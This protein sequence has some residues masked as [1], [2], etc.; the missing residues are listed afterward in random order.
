MIRKIVKISVIMMVIGVLSSCNSN[1]AIE[2]IPS[3]DLEDKEIVTEVIEMEE[4]SMSIRPVTSL[5]PL[6]EYDV[7]V[8]EK[9]NLVYDKLFYFDEN[10][11]WA[12]DIVADYTLDMTTRQL[13]IGLKEDVY[14][15]NGELMTAVDVANSI[16]ILINADEN[17]YYKDKVRNIS[18]YNVRNMD[19][20]QKIVLTFAS[21][22]PLYEIDLSFPIVSSKTY[23]GTSYSMPYGSGNY[24]LDVNDKY[25]EFS[26]TDNPYDDGT[27]NI[28]K[29]NFTVIDNE[30]TEIY[31]FENGII[32]SALTSP[33]EWLKYKKN[34]ESQVFA[35]DRNELEFIG[36]NY[37]NVLLQDINMR[38]AISRAI[39]YEDILED[40]YVNYGELTN[41]GVNPN[42]WLYNDD[43]EP[44]TKSVSTAKKLL[45]DNGYILNS[46]TNTRIKT[47]DGKTYNANFNI[48]VNS[49]N[50]ERVHLANILQSSLESIG[51]QT[52][53]VSLG[54]EEYILALNNKEFDLFI[55][56]MVV[57]SSQLFMKVFT[58]N[59]P[60][61]YG[62]ESLNTLI[63]EISVVTTNDEFESKHR[64]IQSLLSSATTFIPLLYK[65]DVFIVDG[66]VDNAKVF[67]D[68]L[69]YNVDEWAYSKEHIYEK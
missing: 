27:P 36:F 47:I 35:Y 45:D 54:Y 62:S 53:I 20:I 14:F 59:N 25:L 66:E 56:G 65:Y 46:V 3:N 43:I 60:F 22:T 24:L 23:E 39:S 5:N 15:G 16:G 12:S 28:K 2:S 6:L 61:S 58:G 37:N 48:L 26:F 4:M 30:V 51:I 10:M 33:N 13:V 50:E 52:N 11:K 42:S 68:N 18:S 38:Q 55:G 9:L 49:D 17:V 21:N 32:N 41:T 7:D 67:Y 63:E 1:I 69:F 19:G 34:Y 57:D 8:V 64:E 31:S 40:V 29:I 44:I